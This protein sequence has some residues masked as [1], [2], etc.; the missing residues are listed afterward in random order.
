MFRRP[1]TRPAA[2]LR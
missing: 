1:R 2:L